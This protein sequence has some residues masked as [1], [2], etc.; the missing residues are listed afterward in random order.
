MLGVRADGD[1]RQGVRRPA[2]RDRLFTQRNTSNSTIIRRPTLS[3]GNLL[4][5]YRVSD[6]SPTRL[7]RVAV[8]E[9]AVKING[10]WSWLYAAID[11]DTKLILGVDLFGTH[12]T[13]PAAAFL[14]R[15]SEKHDL[16]G[17]VSRRW[18]RLSDC[19]C[20]IRTERSA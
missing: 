13:D 4:L 11:L 9:T 19:P 15:L 5:V 16:R 7:K 3:S 17:R 12:G 1:A 18:L 14:H 10:E 6:N 20:S 2:P 8:D